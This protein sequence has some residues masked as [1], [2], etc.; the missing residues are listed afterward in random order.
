MEPVLRYERNGWLEGLE[1]QRAF[2]EKFAD[3]LPAA[4]WREHERMERRLRA[5]RP[6]ATA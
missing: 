5:A 4:I 2:F 3:R 6:L 1:E